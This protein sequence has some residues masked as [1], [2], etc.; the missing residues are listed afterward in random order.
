M[1]TVRE[2][3]DI[4]EIRACEAI[5]NEV[6]GL[7]PRELVP[8]SQL[9]AVAHAGGLVAAAYA[10]D[11]AIGFVYGFPSLRARYPGIGHH[12]HMLAVLPE[13]RGRGVGRALKF[14]QRDW[15]AAKGMSWI[16]WTFDP[17][18]RKNARLN[19]EHLGANVF[20]YRINEYG[21]MND[22]INR[23]LPSDRLL[24]YWDLESPP[25]ARLPLSPADFPKVLSE[26]GGAPG[27][28]KLGLEAPR[29]AVYAPDLSELGETDVALAWRLA[30]RDVLSHYLARG[31]AVTRLLGDHYLLEKA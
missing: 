21:P 26:E 1:A 11:K 28:A 31:Y 29:L 30:L 20:E 13:Y 24:A 7:A 6:W 2:L 5:E 16:T 18:Q 14:F 9:V 23:G 19:L 15:C 12:S 4:G 8:A 10:G 25:G 27:A 22:A 17:L 3:H